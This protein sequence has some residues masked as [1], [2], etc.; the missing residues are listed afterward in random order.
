[1]LP[2]YPAEDFT[3]V[4]LHTMTLLSAHTLV[5][6]PDQVSLLL[7]YLDGDPRVAVKT[8]VVKDLKYVSKYFVAVAESRDRHVEFCIP[9][10]VSQVP[11]QCEA[12]PLVDRVQHLLHDLLCLVHFDLRLVLPIGP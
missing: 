9:I 7:R 11:G 1:M 8:R 12:R 6:L 4:I 2:S 10:F 3:C 5:D